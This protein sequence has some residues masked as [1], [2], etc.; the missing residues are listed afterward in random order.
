MTSAAGQ[1]VERIALLIGI[2]GRSREGRRL[3]DIASE[4]GLSKST[5]HRLLGSLTRVGFVEQN[6]FTGNFHL[7]FEFFTLGAMA[8]NRYGLVDLAH[9]HL[10]RIEEE[11]HDTVHFNVRWKSESICVDRIEGR[12]PIKV[13]TLNVGSRR[14]LGLGAGSLAL[15]AFLGDD[16]I[17]TVLA[18]NAEEIKGYPGFNEKVIRSLVDQ[19]RNDGYAFNDAMLLPDMCA[20]GVPVMGADKRPLAAI[21]IAAISGRM[22][23]NRRK[24]LLKLLQKEACELEKKIAKLTSGLSDTGL[25]QL[26]AISPA[27][28]DLRF[29]TN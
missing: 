8:V 19:T 11:C 20:I 24:D 18:Q 13:L 10:I 14:P 22:K 17:S 7:S 29:S 6:E 28:F 2:L 23:P 15:L 3:T 26:A 27:R 4:S 1:G 25:R 9:E 21:S 12:F 16:E 5:V